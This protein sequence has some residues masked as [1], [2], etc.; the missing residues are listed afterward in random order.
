MTAQQILGAVII[1]SAALVL[2]AYMAS[3]SG[4]K[5]TLRIWVIALVSAAVV[6]LGCWLLTGGNYRG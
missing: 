6:F 3:L 4:F 1:V 2:F 5:E